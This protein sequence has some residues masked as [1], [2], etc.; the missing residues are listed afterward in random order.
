VRRVEVARHNGQLHIS[1]V[2]QRIRR[3]L[4]AAA[5]IGE[6]V[7][8]DADG[9]ELSKEELSEILEGISA[10][11]VRIIYPRAHGIESG[12]PSC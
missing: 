8:L 7:L 1:K 4:L 3:K 2:R 5:E 10:L 6:C 11:K 12:G 9:A